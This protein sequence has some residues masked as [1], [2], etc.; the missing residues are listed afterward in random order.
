MRR[1]TRALQICLVL[2]LLNAILI[3]TEARPFDVLEKKAPVGLDNGGFF[4]GSSLG[5]ING[6]VADSSGPSPP[7][8]GQ[9]QPQDKL[10]MFDQPRDNPGIN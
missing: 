7:G 6:Q 5:P 9:D 4:D 10:V 2:A 3:E 8:V 1:E